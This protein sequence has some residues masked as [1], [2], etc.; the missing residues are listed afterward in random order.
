LVVVAVETNMKELIAQ[1]IRASGPL[2]IDRYMALCLGHPTLGYYM[3]RDPLGASGDFTTAP[4]INQIFGELIGIW[5]V[6]AWQAVGSPSPFLLVELGPGRGTLMADILRSTAKMQEFADAAQVHLVETSPV[7]RQAQREKLDAQVAWHDSVET[8][9]QEPMIFV[10]NEFFDALPTQQLI[11]HDGKTYERCVDLDGENLVLAIRPIPAIAGL[12][13]GLNEVSLVSSAIAET[14]GTRITAL[15]G[16]GLVID[17]GHLQTAAG[18]TLQ[19]LKSHNFVGVTDFPGTSDLTVHVDFEALAK[20]FG[21]GGAEVLTAQTQGEFLK[22]M[23][24]EA[25]VTKLAAKLVG[26]ERQDFVAGAARLVDDK[27][28]GQLFKVMAVAQ[29]LRQPIYPFE[30]P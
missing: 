24:I 8:L 23:G 22:S 17:Y 30:A 16:A 10:A 2:P 18:D 29:A 15:G 3:N 9:P 11:L 26:K 27:E 28:M 1:I 7:L 13:D 14:L 5:C 12:Q 21:K 6:A 25:R 20:G 19:A 4:E